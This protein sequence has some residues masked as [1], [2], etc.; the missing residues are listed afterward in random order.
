MD[1]SD[2][3]IMDD[4]ERQLV[5]DAPGSLLPV[6]WQ[7]FAAEY[8]IHGKRRKA[9]IAAGYSVH[10]AS[11]VAASLLRRPEVKA[12]IEEHKNERLA[13][14]GL[15]SDRVLE[16][17]LAIAL[18]DIR[19]VATW[20]EEGNV[21]FKSSQAVGGK[22]ARAISSIKRRKSTD[23]AGNVIEEVTL[24]MNPKMPALNALMKALGLQPR[25]EGI[26]INVKN[27]N[28]N[29]A[30]GKLELSAIDTILAAAEDD[31]EEP[32]ADRPLED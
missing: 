16:E 5:A 8:S 32:D 18:A 25:G 3:V 30:A 14:I 28:Q 21:S 26:N 15:R 27:Q 22:A 23:P 12:L 31:K 2:V 6:R 24:E 1:V 4:D 7:Y 9:A 20:D 19:D 17:V 10:S 11:E 29:I 13:R